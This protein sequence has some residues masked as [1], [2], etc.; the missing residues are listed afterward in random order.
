MRIHYDHLMKIKDILVPGLKTIMVDAGMADAEK[1]MR[2]ANIRHLP[3]T[4]GTRIVGIISDRDIQRSQTLVKTSDVTKTT[5][6]GF[7]KVADYMS[8]PAR[9][10][11]V[12]DSI[13]KLTR[14][15][16]DMK[17]SSFI[18]EDD[19]RRPLGI[20]TTYDL[21]LLLMD[22]LTKPRPTDIVRKLFRLR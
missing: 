18:I 4:D 16:I 2:E 15:M 19:N 20:I 5:I 14:E 1:I 22:Q 12:N 13:E 17:I 9:T 10:M 8:S 6:Q 3:V 21:L 11:N 7:K